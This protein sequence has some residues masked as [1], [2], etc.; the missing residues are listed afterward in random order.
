MGVGEA[1]NVI[2]QQSQTDSKW[3]P[4]S[5]KMSLEEANIGTARSKHKEGDVRKVRDLL[6]GCGKQLESD[7]KSILYEDVQ[8]R[9][10]MSREPHNQENGSRLP[11][12][13][14]L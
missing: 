10:R 8:P 4:L 9:E 3:Q 7:T 1:Y 11:E 12:T 6:Q 13:G 2:S 14:I 5:Q